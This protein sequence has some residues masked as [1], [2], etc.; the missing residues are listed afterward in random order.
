MIIFIIVL[1]IIAVVFIL[2][3]MGGLESYDPKSDNKG[4]VSNN[5]SDSATKDEFQE[6]KK[7][8]FEQKYPKIKWR[9]I[10]YATNYFDYEER[11]FDNEYE[12][13]DL[14]RYLIS[15]MRDTKDYFKPARVEVK[16]VQRIG[17][18]NSS[19]IYYK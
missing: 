14:E 4:F 10:R 15:G 13:R 12:A 11:D 9:V 1:I 17:N 19:Y 18:E 6:N 3:V 2:M 16:M 7:I 5:I 8:E